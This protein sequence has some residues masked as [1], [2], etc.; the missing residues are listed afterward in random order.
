MFGLIAVVLGVLI[1]LKV[2]WLEPRSMEKA[3]SQMALRGEPRAFDSYL[4]SRRYRLRR[5]VE[6]T[7]GSAIIVIGVITLF[8][9]A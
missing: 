3:R 7:A 9:G 2:W 5:G 8:H 6:L 1:W 4:R